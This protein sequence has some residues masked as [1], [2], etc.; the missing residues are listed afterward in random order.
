M[1]ITF[2]GHRSLTEHSALSQKLL[3]TFREN[4]P[5]A[6]PLRFYCG[7]Y[8]EFDRLCA[9][10][11]RLIQKEYP[12]SRICYISPYLLPKKDQADSDAYDEIIYPPLES[13]PPRLA[14]LKRNQWMI[15][16][17]DLVITYVKYQGGAFQTLE[18]AQ[19][20]KKRIINLAI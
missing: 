9:G 11:C 18:Y 3:A 19:K 5:K 4:L 17:A 12:N 13:V 20:R 2:A 8:G 7:G 14:I 16:Q 1:I 6:E 10:A 15:D